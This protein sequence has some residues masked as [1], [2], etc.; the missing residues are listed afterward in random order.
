[1]LQAVIIDIIYFKFYPLFLFEIEVDC[2]GCRKIRV[3]IVQYHLSLANL[4]VIGCLGVFDEYVNL[5]VT[6]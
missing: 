6:F 2:K 4:N 5:G 1:M 3:Q